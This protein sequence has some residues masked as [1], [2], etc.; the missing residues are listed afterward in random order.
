MVTGTIILLLATVFALAGCNKLRSQPAFRAHL[1][2]LVP[3]ALVNSTAVLVPVA[4]MILAVALLNSTTA[5][6]ALLGTIGLLAVFTGAL[7]VT[8]SLGLK[9]CG[10]FGEVQGEATVISGIIRNVLLIFCAAIALHE[11]ELII[12]A[13]DISTSLGQITLVLGA[14]CLWP[15]LVAL[16]NRRKFLL[17]WS[18]EP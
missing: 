14:I 2:N 3:P 16:A 1:R 12:F 8:K 18:P 13:K 7:L 15:C 10:C 9:S 5:R 4:E 17:H 6:V 11:K